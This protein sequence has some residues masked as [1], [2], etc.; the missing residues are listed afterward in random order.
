MRLQ[1]SS[2]TVV[3]IVCRLALP[4][5]QQLNTQ[6]ASHAQRRGDGEVLAGRGRGGRRVGGGPVSAAAARRWVS[7]GLQSAAAVW[8]TH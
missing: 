5:A 7:A 4:L 6:A 2:P 1:A 8:C 3:S